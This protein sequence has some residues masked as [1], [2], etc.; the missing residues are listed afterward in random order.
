MIVRELITK[1]GFEIDS[2]KLDEF[3]K[4]LEKTKKQLKS[5]RNNFLGIYSAISV[6]G[7]GLNA[8]TLNVAKS[9]NNTDLLA[10]QLGIA[11]QT[12]QELET[13]SQNT[14]LKVGELSNSFLNFSKR[15]GDARLST[16]G[17]SKD[18]Q[19]LGLSLKDNQGNIRDLS[20]LYSEAAK[21]INQ[22]KDPT[23]QIALSQRLFGSSNLELSKFMGQS[24]EALNAQ[25]EE[26]RKLSYIVDNKAIKSSKEFLKSWSNLK[27]IFSGIKT[28]LAIGLMPVFNE[29]IDSFKKW[30]IEN[31]G[32]ISQNIDTTIQSL[33]IA[34]QGLLKVL[35]LIITPIKFIIN[36]M[37]GLD[38]ALRIA[39][40]SIL[41]VWI[42]KA[43]QA[44]NA[45]R[46]A[47]LTN[48]FAIVIAGIGA[49][50]AIL[51]VLIEDIALWVSGNNSAIESVLG[52]WE[53]FS[54]KFSAIWDSVVTGFKDGL[55]SIGNFGQTIFDSIFDGIVSSIN[56]IL[57]LFDTIK[58]KTIFRDNNNT[59]F[60]SN[61]NKSV[62]NLLT[63][64]SINLKNSNVARKLNL[65]NENNLVDQPNIQSTS[66]PIIKPIIQPSG[67]ARNLT[68]NSNLNTVSQT[69]NENITINVPVGTTQEQAEVISS[70]VSKEIQ[71]QFNQNILRGL[72]AL[73]LR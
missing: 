4:S 28:Q 34:F 20:D 61:S 38:N 6:V 49:I 43:V 21:K 5:F 54:K 53:N 58:Q 16:A 13:A 60:A 35:N 3:E 67:S 59:K 22:L 31:K 69:I 15:V 29:M 73:A 7:A 12:L 50:V 44:F 37:G 30:F 1:L 14:G 68:R 64:D 46:I 70:Q 11:S 26:I 57:N 48:P 56:K 2:K 36:L 24:T 17:T 62:K 18:F 27:I 33:T 55:T 25:R 42:Y 9:I 39:G 72:D 47:M 51:A 66:T 45:L 32:I 52:S 19:D 40:I 71:Q 41:I 8:L 10:N 65:V 63:D 23:K